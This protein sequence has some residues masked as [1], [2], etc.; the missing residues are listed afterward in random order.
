MQLL[1]ST[2]MSTRVVQRTKIIANQSLFDAL[3]AQ[4]RQKMQVPNRPGTYPTCN[5]L[6]FYQFLTGKNLLIVDLGMNE[7]FLSS[8][9]LLLYYKWWEKVNHNSGVANLAPSPHHVTSMQ[10]F[11]DIVET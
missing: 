4:S 1:K 7:C 9:S 6:I 2:G 5:A 11:P 3:K 10:V 8:E